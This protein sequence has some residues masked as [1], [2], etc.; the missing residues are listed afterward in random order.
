MTALAWLYGLL[1]LPLVIGFFWTDSETGSQR[2]WSLLALCAYCALGGAVLLL[3]A[4][5][6]PAATP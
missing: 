1:S 5:R 3:V 2:R 4:L 6:V